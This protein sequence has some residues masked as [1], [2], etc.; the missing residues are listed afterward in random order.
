M[1][2]YVS[3]ELDCISFWTEIITVEKLHGKLF[4]RFCLCTDWNWYRLSS[5]ASSLTGWG[6]E[7]DAKKK[8][9]YAALIDGAVSS[10]MAITTMHVHLK[11]AY[12]YHFCCPEKKKKQKRRSEKKTTYKRL[13]WISYRNMNKTNKKRR[14]VDGLEI[15]SFSFAFELWCDWELEK[16]LQ[17]VM[18]DKLAKLHIIFIF[19]FTYIIRRF[20]FTLGHCL[21]IRSILSSQEIASMPKY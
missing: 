20:L 15:M 18:R 8:T 14:K 1:L 9:I 12:M 7:S 5:S 2:Q 10:A 16:V 21:C 19:H 3:F 4:A 17:K 13:K 11:F 6:G